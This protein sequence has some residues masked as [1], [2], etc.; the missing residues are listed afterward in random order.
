MALQWYIKEEV[1]KLIK[2]GLTK[3]QAIDIITSIYR[4]GIS[5]CNSYFANGRNENIGI[6][7]LKEILVKENIE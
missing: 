5:D 3:E 2:L 7:T 6:Q 1:N 4:W